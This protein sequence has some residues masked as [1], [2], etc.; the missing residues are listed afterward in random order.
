M[1]HP[2]LRFACLDLYTIPAGNIR[3][4]ATKE[5]GQGSWYCCAQVSNLD[6]H[7]DDNDHHYDVADPYAFY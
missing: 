5:E 3:K 1:G 7:Q 4:S 6:H 2:L